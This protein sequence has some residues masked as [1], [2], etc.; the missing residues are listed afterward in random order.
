VTRETPVDLRSDTVT[1]PTPAMMEAMM[2]AEV[3][4]DVYGEDPTVN[5]L[6]SEVATL[7]GKEAALFV[8]SGTMANQISLK[9]HTQPG[10]EV[11]VHPQ[12]HILRAESAAGAALC[13]VQFRPVGD[14]DG[15]MT[16][17]QVAAVLQSG[18]NPHFA[19]TRLVCLEN[20]HN[21]AGGTVLSLDGMEAVTRFAHEQ[22]LRAHLDGARML[23]AC[24]A[25]D[26]QPGTMAAGFDSVTLCFSKGLG[27]PVGSI[28]AGQREFIARCYRYRKM[29]GGA[30]RQAG[31]LAA[32]ARH[33]LAHHVERLAEDHANAKRLAE[34]LREIS[35]ITL[36]NG[37]PVTNMVF[38][39]CDPAR[40]SLPDLVAALG[41]QGVL[42]GTMAPDVA[43]AVTHLDVDANAIDRALSVIEK[44]QR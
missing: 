8:A 29:F 44:I 9:A 31:F 21:A 7:M 40:R 11:V 24:V 33:A 3:G 37:P 27:A 28:I 10:D 32:A 23:N 12:A 38:F 5:A 22:G 39:G 2:A 6:E 19:P 41:E 18:E 30:M 42:I 4:D 20:T 17:D 16:T 34:G 43:R 14:A 1:K 35:G 15:G 13:G 26:V 25:G 36:P